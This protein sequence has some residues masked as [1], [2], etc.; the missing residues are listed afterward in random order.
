MSYYPQVSASAL[1]LP[2]VYYP[3]ALSIGAAG[4]TANAVWVLLFTLPFAK[5]INSFTAHVGA[6]SAGTHWGT[7]LYNAAGTVLLASTTFSTAAVGAITNTLGSPVFL[8]PGNY[9]YASTSDS[10]LNGIDFAR[11][12]AGASYPNFSF[13]CANSSSA[14]VLP[15]TTGALTSNL[16]GNTTGIVLV[17]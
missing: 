7:G 14:G 1:W 5:I 8:P 12:S 10:L 9:L 6:N 15:S 11:S 13:S 17:L 2:T 3:D 4:L 16:A